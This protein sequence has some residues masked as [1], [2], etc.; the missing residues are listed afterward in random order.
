MIKNKILFGLGYFFFTLILLFGIISWSA[1]AYTI[2]S[3]VW[4][5]LKSGYWVEL[6]LIYLLVG[7]SPAMSSSVLPEKVLQHLGTLSNPF[8]VLEINNLLADSNSLREWLSE[9]QSWPEVHG[10]VVRLLQS[11]PI[12]TFLLVFGVLL[13][14]CGLTIMSS[15][16][17]ETNER[18]LKKKEP[19]DRNTLP[20]EICGQKVRTSKYQSHWAHCF[21]RKEKNNAK[22][23]R[24]E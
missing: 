20:C 13:S 12:S 10:I 7:F 8:A 21:L 22:S 1:G 5:F 23:K 2:V 6:P 19:I 15:I 24:T 14:L 3:Q 11:L 4:L 16:R 17:E 18:P 9:P